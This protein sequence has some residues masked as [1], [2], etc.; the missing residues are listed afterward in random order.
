MS[1]FFEEI[2]RLAA[3]RGIRAEEKEDCLHLEMDGTPLC[4]V[5]EDGGVRYRKS[6][7]GTSVRNQML[8]D[9][10]EET[11][12][13]REYV[14]AMEAA[15]FL[16]ATGL[17][18][19]KFKLL[20]D[21]GGYVLAGQ[22]RGRHGFQFVTWEWSYD[23]TGVG[24]GNYWESNY[25][26]AKEN[27]AVRSGLV[28]RDRLF[29]Q[30]QSMELYRLVRQRLVEAL[31]DRREKNLL[32]ECQRKMERSFSGLERDYFIEKLADDP[33]TGYTL[34]EPRRKTSHATG[35]YD[36]ASGTYLSE[37]NPDKFPDAKPFESPYD[38]LAKLCQDKP[39]AGLRANV[40]SPACS[41]GTA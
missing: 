23:H 33:R 36:E 19:E 12:M 28:S 15:P 17:M 32:D 8:L 30:E 24:T 21:Y 3:Q 6:D 37:A 40:G 26:C 7:T 11:Q 13:T 5:M 1:R 9:I 18:D 16:K 29:D 34:I 10:T 2:A 38:G 31:P 41:E 25:R 20:M 14:S 35:L 4:K 39:S 27:F 22:D